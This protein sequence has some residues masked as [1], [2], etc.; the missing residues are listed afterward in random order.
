LDSLFQPETIPLHSRIF[1][2]PIKARTNNQTGWTMKNRLALLCLTVAGLISNTASAH[3]ILLVPKTADGK[4]M[5]SIEST[6]SFVN[7]E[8]LEE[9]AN[10]EAMI[11][12]P[13][14]AEKLVVAQGGPLSLM[15]QAA[16]PTT[17]AYFVAHRLPLIYS[18]TPDGYKPGTRAENPTAIFTNRY[19][20]YSKALVG[21]TDAAFAMAPLGHELEIVPMSN[22]ADL[23]AGDEL[24]VQV[25][26]QGQPIAAEIQATFAGFSDTPMTFAYATETSETDVGVATV[27]VWQPGYWYVRVA[28]EADDAADDVD[29]H[30][31][32]AILSFDVK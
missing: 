27:K 26:Y 32:R 29:T 6:H 15:A 3:E 5:V 10:I 4:L 8:E 7:A 9:A 28:H 11:I 18:N 12:S 1:V 23:K 30:V 19:E 17:A 22:P 25:L 31:L 24:K 14:G 2:R 20:K 21:T 16:A 13:A